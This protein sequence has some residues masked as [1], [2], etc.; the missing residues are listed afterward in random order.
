MGRRGRKADPL[1]GIKRTL[2]QGVEWM[3]EKQVARFEKKLN[4]GNPKGEVTIAWQC[5]QKLRTVYHA[6]A[7][8]GRELITEILQSL[9]SC[10]IPEVAKLGRSLRM[11]KAAA[12]S[13]PPIN[14]L[15]ASRA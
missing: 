14:Q 10:P 6:A 15:V 12:V 2:Q 9:P 1:F 5:Y 4:E 11:W 3:T 13:Y 7:A 8:K